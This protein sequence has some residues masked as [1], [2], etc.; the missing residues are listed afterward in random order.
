MSDIKLYTRVLIVG[1]NQFDIEEAIRLSTSAGVHIEQAQDSEWAVEQFDKHPSRILLLCHSNVE[2][3]HKF[4]TSFLMF[5]EKAMDSP[6]QTIVL[7]DG[8]ESQQAYEYCIDKIIDDYVVYKP[9]FDVHRVK[10]TIKLA[11]ERLRHIDYKKRMEERLAQMMSHIKEL[12]HTMK[13]QMEKSHRVQKERKKNDHALEDII[14]QGLQRVRG[15]LDELSGNG[16]VNINDKVTFD[17]AYN[18][19][20]KD[21]LDEVSQQNEEKEKNELSW[22][23]DLQKSFESSNESTATLVEEA[24]EQSEDQEKV[25][26][27][28]VE[29]ELVNQKMMSMI[30]SSEGYDVQVAAD[31]ITAV[32]LAERWLPDIILMDIRMPKMNG[33]K[34]TKRLKSSPLFERTV[35]IMLTAHSEE[36][37]VRECLKSGASDFIVKPAKKKELLERLDYFLAKRNEM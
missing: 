30:L 16:T 10:F 29:D 18:K 35:I 14:E 27:L 36:V 8:K 4:Y 31:G 5:S 20:Q 1:D 32:M 24:S 12:K 37:V 7:C 11:T 34:V 13:E 6:H 25:K 9:L 15:K 17:E 22:I 26:V 21:I 19:Y 2:Q 3:A 23:S 28:I 33:L